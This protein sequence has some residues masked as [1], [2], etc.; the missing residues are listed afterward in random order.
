MASSDSASY[1]SAG[2][3]YSDL[4]LES[5]VESTSSEQALQASGAL[6]QVAN[7][8]NSHQMVVHNPEHAEWHRQMKLV[9]RNRI[10]DD[11]RKQYNKKN[12]ALT[13]WIYNHL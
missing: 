12:E 5:D 13:M 8:A 6:V 1:R 4:E 3:S 7:V 9:A 11:T 2:Q 10:T